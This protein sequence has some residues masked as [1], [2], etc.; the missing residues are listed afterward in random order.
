MPNL[1]PGKSSCSASASRC[2]LVCQNACLASG[3][4]HLWSVS[5]ASH[6]MGRV[7]SHAS[8]L[9]V[10]ASTSAA[11]RS[12]M[13]LA[14][15]NGVVPLAYSLTL[16]SGN[17]ILIISLYVD[18]CLHNYGGVRHAAADTKSTFASGAGAKSPQSY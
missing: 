1:T 14:I 4:S 15:S 18:D 11:R 3:S 16:L 17:V 13:L 5:V 7:K 12:L 10:A 9:T 8:S 2:A 6:S